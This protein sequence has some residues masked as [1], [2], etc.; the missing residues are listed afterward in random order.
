M[1]DSATILCNKQ[2]EKRLK[3][4]MRIPLT[5]DQLVGMPTWVG[6]PFDVI[7]K[8]ENSGKSLASTMELDPMLLR[9][10]L[11]PNT[12]KE[13]ITL[14]GVRMCGFKVEHEP[15]EEIALTFRAYL[16]RTGRFLKFA[17][18]NFGSSLFIRYE[19]AQQSLLDDNPNVQPQGE[20]ETDDDQQPDE[21]DAEEDDQPTGEE[22]DKK[23]ALDPSR[24]A[25]F[26]S[27]KD[28]ALLD[29]R[30]KRDSR[31]LASVQ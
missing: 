18:D 3:L 31:T 20:P 13:A 27:A 9:V 28:K 4:S 24:D 16:P 1:I 5:G 6:A 29:K 26:A 30:K 11:L 14:D 17:D 22:D 25:E 8:P 21:E 19:A 12:E 2:G 23:S 15:D 10:F 7:A